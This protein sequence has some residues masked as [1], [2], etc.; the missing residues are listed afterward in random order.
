ML[1]KNVL[2]VARQHGHSIMTLLRT[3]AAW[4]EGAVEA[5]VQAIEQSMMLTRTR[6]PRER[7]RKTSSRWRSTL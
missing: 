5:D 3:Y 7:P 6:A 4:T 2:W 1:G